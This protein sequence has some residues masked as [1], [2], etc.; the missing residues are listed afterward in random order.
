[1]HEGAIGSRFLLIVGL[2]SSTKPLNDVNAQTLSASKPG[3]EPV[4]LLRLME[5]KKQDH[6]LIRLL[7]MNRGFEKA[8]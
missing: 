7:F 8:L 4:F 1:M 6:T 2:I 3:F 5:K